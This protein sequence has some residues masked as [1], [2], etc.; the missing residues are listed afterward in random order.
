MDL[1]PILTN[2]RL[3]H[4]GGTA[5]VM[6]TLSFGSL[7]DVRNPCQNCHNEI[8]QYNLVKRIAS[9]GQVHSQRP[10]QSGSNYSLI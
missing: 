8:M 2:G 1:Q 10:Y 3:F 5:I 7:H 4:L 9:P 6:K